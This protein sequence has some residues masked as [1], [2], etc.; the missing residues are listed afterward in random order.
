MINH[1]SSH[2]VQLN[3]KFD[4]MHKK[5]GHRR[6]K[7]KGIEETTIRCK[8]EKEKDFGLKNVSLLPQFNFFLLQTTELEKNGSIEQIRDWGSSF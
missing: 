7:R 1:K 8:Q 6:I 5:S 2:H 3:S 4:S